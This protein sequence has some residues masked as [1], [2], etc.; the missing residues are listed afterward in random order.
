MLAL[1]Q[2]SLHDAGH[3]ESSIA[4]Q[5]ELYA[6]TFLPLYYHCHIEGLA[7]QDHSNDSY[8]S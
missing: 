5:A 2:R 8:E 7:Q 4:Q 3:L 1:T 6:T